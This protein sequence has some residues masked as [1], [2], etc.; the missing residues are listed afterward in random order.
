MVD[1]SRAHFLRSRSEKG[2]SFFENE[3]SG[4]WMFK[5]S[6]SAVLLFEF[7]ETPFI[8][9]EPLS[10]F[11]HL[12]K[13]LNW[14]P[15]NHTPSRHLKKQMQ[16]LFTFTTKISFFSTITIYSKFWLS[17]KLT[18]HLKTSKPD[19]KDR[20]SDWA[21]SRRRDPSKRSSL[22]G[23]H[24]MNLAN[25]CNFAKSMKVPRRVCQITSA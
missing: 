7:E 3:V 4:K 21:E 22:A 11:L 1:F 13:A 5:F 20:N 9:W 2:K 8:P 6:F 24:S 17:S 16:V 19:F 18:L 23:R 15:A 12:S 10:D 25:S 14:Q